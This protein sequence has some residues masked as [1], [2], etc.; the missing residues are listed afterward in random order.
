[1]GSS[2]KKYLVV[3]ITMSI[4]RTEFNEREW[5]PSTR[6]KIFDFLREH[7]DMAYTVDEIVKA[8]GDKSVGNKATEQCLDTLMQYHK[9]R[10]ETKKEQVY[11]IIIPGRDP[12]PNDMNKEEREK[13]NQK[14]KE[15]QEEERKKRAERMARR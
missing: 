1:M 14:K 11:F 12:L 6:R 8:V 5:K 3:V 15:E 7:E 9:V 10:M 13:Y 2:Q 4:T